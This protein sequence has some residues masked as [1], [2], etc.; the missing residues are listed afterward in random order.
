[1][2][3]EKWKMENEIF[4]NRYSLFTINYLANGQ[5]LMPYFTLLLFPKAQFQ[6]PIA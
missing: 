6:I 4:P 3:N 1:M 2:K 5:C